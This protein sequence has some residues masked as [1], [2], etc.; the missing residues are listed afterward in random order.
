MGITDDQM[1][2]EDKWLAAWR[3][4][5]QRLRWDRVPVQVGDAA[6]DL[7]L[8]SS[9]GDEVTLSSLWATGPALLLFWRHYGCSCGIDRAARLRDEH[10]SFV[11][12][13]ASVVIIGQGGPA[14]SAAYADRNGIP[15]PILSD[16]EQSS[17]RAYDLLEGTTAQILFDAPDEFLRCELGAGENLAASRHDT[18]R[19]LVDNPW[20]L[21][22]EFVIGGDGT[23]SLA[24]R[25][26][27]C[28]DFPDP[29]VLLAAIRF[30]AR[31]GS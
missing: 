9:A 10:Q 30:G 27:F 31:T 20:Q 1:A 3:A 15:C 11:D 25:Y 17:Y 8:L 16:P 5:P 22:G 29:R 26:Q 28:E 18:D 6:P 7:T 23:V 24:Y 21:P 4:G 13:G 14:R 12:A 19:A 2:A